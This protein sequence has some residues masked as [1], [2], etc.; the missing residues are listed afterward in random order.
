MF[1]FVA[2]VGV[3]F[4]TRLHAH[5]SV[6]GRRSPRRV[7]RAKSRR[8]RGPGARAP[9]LGHVYFYSRNEGGLSTRANVIKTD[10]R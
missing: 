1:F 10:V 9:V 4:P 2:T 8:R 3:P 7:P 5:V 6:R